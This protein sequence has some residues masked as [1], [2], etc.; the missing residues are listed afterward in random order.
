[1]GV[2]MRAST[3]IFVAILLW[4]APAQAF[5]LSE[6][7]LEEKSVELGVVARAFSFLMTG[8]I[9]DVPYTKSV[10]SPQ[11]YDAD[12]TSLSLFDLRLSFIYKNPR[13][14]VV[15]HNQLSGSLRAH[16]MTG[17]LAMGRGMEPRRFLPLQ[18][19]L[20]DGDTYSLREA[21]DWAYV[22][23][24]LG[25]VTITM[26][27]Q[28]VSFG[29]GKMFFPTDLVSTFSITE[30]DTEYK[31]GSDALRLDWTVRPSTLL[32]VVAAAGKH[33]EQSLAEQLAG[34]TPDEELS[35]AGSSFVARVQQTW[36]PVEVALLAG[37]IRNDLVVGLDGVYDVG[38]FDLYAEVTVTMPRD[39]S[40]TP[41]AEAPPQLPGL[42]GLQTD[43]AVVRALVGA[44]FKPHADV[45]IS[46][47][48][49]F[50]GFGARDKEQYL[51]VAISQRVAVGEQSTLG[52][53]YLGG[54][55]I[56][57]A[58]PLL[59]LSAVGLFNL[60]DPSGLVSVGGS[61]NVA[62]NV[63]LKAGLYL[64]LGRVPDISKPLLPTPR[65]EF[66]MYPTFFF[67]ELKAAM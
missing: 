30:V 43:P 34:V 12:P 19:D 6:D 26:G 22:A 35:L 57:E 4:A 16:A 59:T 36:T 29:R 47:E 18:A 20:A 51:Y 49:Y 25:P 13:F 31:P 14:K 54:L 64:P 42:S 28:P 1:M 5:V 15:L 24:V 37:L 61:Y 63:E 21:V 58:H 67:V 60:R 48:L 65:S 38:P 17:S 7:P 53:L 9:L 11:G 23:V 2:V 40:L 3:V 56:W 52:M 45:T 55:C 32:T 39:R 46:P 44:T 27:R 33:A 8:P 50:N 62:S 10:L 66:G 41:N